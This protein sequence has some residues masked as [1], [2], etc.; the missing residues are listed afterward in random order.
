MPRYCHPGASYGCGHHAEHVEAAKKG[1]RTR[2]GQGPVAALRNAE[3]ILSDLYGDTVTGAHTHKSHPK[4]VRFKMSGKWFRVSTGEFHALVKEGAKVRRE[5]QRAAARDARANARERA[6][7]P[8]ARLR[9]EIREL[10]YRDAMMRIGEDDTA[11]TYKNTLA[12]L[13]KRGISPSRHEKFYRRRNKILPVDYGE[14]ETLPKSLRR[15]HGGYSL[16]D[17]ANVFA[18]EGTMSPDQAEAMTISDSMDRLEQMLGYEAAKNAG[19]ASRADDIA[20]MQGELR[21]ARAQ[22][23]TALGTKRRKASKTKTAKGDEAA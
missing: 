5:Q 13:R 6:S 11:A 23:D 10:Q 4:E 8:V 16:D 7:A 1:W 3:S 2:R 14:W 12:R 21:A 20:R 17:L 9:D 18:E 19:R 22:R 15:R